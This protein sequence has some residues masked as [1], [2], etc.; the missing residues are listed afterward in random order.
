MYDYVGGVR[1]IENRV[2]RFVGIA[3]KRVK[4][5]YLRILRYFRFYSRVRPDCTQ[6]DQPS[7]DAIRNNASGLES[8]LNTIQYR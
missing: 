5:D 2:V 8:K 1:D 3:D 6:H 4:E 7:I